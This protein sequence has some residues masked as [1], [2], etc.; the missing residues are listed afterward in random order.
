[1]TKTTV[2]A[3]VTLRRRL[4]TIV[5]TGL[6]LAGVTACGDSDTRPRTFGLGPTPQVT[7]P[8]V[9][10]PP[11]PVNTV[12]TVTDGWTGAPVAGTRI[13]L[14][15]S[16]HVTDAQGRA[17]VPLGC[18]RATL[19][20]EGFLERRVNCLVGAALEGRTPI[21]L[22]PVANDEERRALRQ[23]LFI[24][25]RLT[26]ATGASGMTVGFASTLRDAADVE[27]VYR[28]AAARI[29]DLTG[30]RVTVPFAMPS[31][32]GDGYVISE[33]PTPPR[34]T[35]N[36]FTW[37]FAVA[38]FCW[39][40]TPDYFVLDLTIDGARITRAD[41]ALRALL[42]GWG[43]RQHDAPGLLNATAP[44]ADLTEFERRSLHMASL[45]RAIEWPDYER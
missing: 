40:P 26:L 37:T 17:E 43:M 38:G 11:P 44:A 22:W 39:E 4:V 31:P 42:Y 3:V 6:L 15:A 41:V 29:S 10:S 7:A 18:A 20:A 27:A 25:D 8:P 21:T 12:I 35:H 9:V 1:M 24:A 45:R 34:C 14:A 33:A 16:T 28:A 19:T 32:G 36:W 5:A 30:G 23:S 2:S 13:T